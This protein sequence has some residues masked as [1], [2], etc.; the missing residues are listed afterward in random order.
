VNLGEEEDVIAIP[1][2]ALLDSYV[3]VVNDSTAERRDVV[4]GLVGDK[5][6][7]IVTGIAE[8]ENVVVIGQQRL[9]GG[10]KVNPIRRELISNEA[11]SI[12]GSE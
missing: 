5:T 4:V 3:F 10:E 2:D 9:A 12:P 8:G 7:E 6:V 11:R 1:K